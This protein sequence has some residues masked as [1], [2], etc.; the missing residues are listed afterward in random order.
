M[1][2][3]EW[4]PSDEELEDLSEAQ[5]EAVAA[6]AASGTPL[7]GGVTPE[8]VAECLVDYFVFKR[9]VIKLSWARRGRGAA[10][11]SLQGCMGFTC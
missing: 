11:G 9:C 1:L 6:A 5:I 2:S 8:D 10:W 4:Q 7:F 3:E